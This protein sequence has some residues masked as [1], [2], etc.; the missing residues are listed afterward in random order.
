MADGNAPKRVF[1]RK[2]LYRMDFQFI[3]EKLQEDIYSFIAEKYGEYFTDRGY[4]QENTVDIEINTNS[5][6]IP[7][8]NARPQTVYYLVHPKVDGGDGRTIKIGKTFV[9]LDIDL[10]VESE[11]ISYYAWFANIIDFLNEKNLFKPVRVGLRKF[12]TFYILHQNIDKMSEIFS[13]PFYECVDETLFELDHF[14][15]I[16]VYSGADYSLNFG[17][18]YNTGFLNN[19]EF[20][21][22]KAHQIT[23]DFD[24]FSDKQEQLDDFCK[25]AEK[26]LEE[27]NHKIYCF[28]KK[29]VSE[30][31][32][33]KL[34][35]GELLNEYG[36]IP[37]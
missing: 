21:N 18:G 23:F 28:F 12:N 15:N 27:M 37:F 35:A 31:I 17:R 11:R 36:I 7:K 9:F 5:P 26:S 34:N 1:L 13:V 8:F 19:E 10:G 3:T 30:K 20:N 33:E 32:C 14:N 29:I 6:D 16:Q 2:V 25:N 4:E 24:L 22:E